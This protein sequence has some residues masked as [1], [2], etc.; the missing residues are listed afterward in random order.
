MR[1]ICFNFKKL[2]K[3]A[4]LLGADPCE[5]FSQFAWKK[6]KKKMVMMT[7]TAAA[8]WLNTKK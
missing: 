6:K 7:E 5:D 3:I 2:I 4:N 1:L 8:I